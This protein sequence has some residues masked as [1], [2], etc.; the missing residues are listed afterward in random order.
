MAGNS[1]HHGDIVN[2]LELDDS[3]SSIRNV[4]NS[5]YEEIEIVNCHK[6]IISSERFLEL[7]MNSQN[8]FSKFIEILQSKLNVVIVF[9]TRDIESIVTSGLK[10]FV[11]IVNENNVKT[12]AKIFGFRLN[13]IN[14]YF[15]LNEVEANMHQWISQSYLKIRKLKINCISINYSCDIITSILN[16]LTN[17]E[18][19]GT[20][21]K[22]LSDQK[23][24]NR[25]NNF[26][27]NNFLQYSE[28]CA[29]KFKSEEK[30]NFIRYTDFKFD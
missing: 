20:I 9:I 19:E 26:K 25:F 1:F 12:Y 4:V 30:T 13:P 23:K 10:H 16:F 17:F 22:L 21:E 14:N 8:T 2:R 29:K 6:I 7:I 28:F 27:Q 3:E 15:D 5:L 11:S 18:S 24:M